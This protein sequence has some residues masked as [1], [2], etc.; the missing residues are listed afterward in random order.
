M[1]TPSLVKPCHM[2]S[3]LKKKKCERGGEREDVKRE[4]AKREGV[5]EGA[6]EAVKEGERSIVKDGVK[7]MQREKGKRAKRRRK[8]NNDTSEK[9]R[10]EIGIA[11]SSRN[12]GKEG[13]K[14]GVCEGSVGSGA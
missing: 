14:G 13:E 3:I 10:I 8:T 9:L 11:L 1:V 4:G 5:K 6:K 2:S 12:N 7:I